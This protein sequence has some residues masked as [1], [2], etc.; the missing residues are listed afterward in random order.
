MVECWTLECNYNSA[1]VINKLFDSSPVSKNSN[2]TN[3][4][5]A[6]KVDPESIEEV[7]LL[8]I[9]DFESLGSSIV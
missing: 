4:A 5:L 1:R 7:R 9:A 6:S 8:N 2:S 3:V